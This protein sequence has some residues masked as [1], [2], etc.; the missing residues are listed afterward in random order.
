MSR[1]LQLCGLLHL[2]TVSKFWMTT[3]GLL[4]RLNFLDFL[5]L[6]LSWGFVAD[7]TDNAGEKEVGVQKVFPLVDTKRSGQHSIILLC[8]APIALS[9]S[10]PNA[11]HSPLTYNKHLHC[12]FSEH[13]LRL[14]SLQLV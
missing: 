13:Y 11:D 14:L 12:C 9:S 2:E 10:I 4:G 3:F 7:I 6:M 1:V 8:K 5:S